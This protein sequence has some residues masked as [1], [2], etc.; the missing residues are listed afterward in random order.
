MNRGTGWFA[1]AFGLLVGCASP[2]QV[3]EF[4]A[5]EGNLAARAAYYLRAGEIGSPST[6]EPGDRERLDAG[7]QAAIRAELTKKGYVETTDASRAQFVVSYQVAGTRRIVMA[8]DRRFG[9]PSPNSVL[10]PSA[11]PPPPLSEAPREQVVRSG[12]VMVLAEEPASGAV[13]WRGMISA[14]TRVGSSEQGI[15][16]AEDMARHITQRFPAR[17]GQ[18]PK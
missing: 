2:W 9:A 7:L 13:L 12:S 4:A 8:D 3:D 16:V 5:P 10:S 14:D 11:T 17:P 18:A 15:R 6:V 1:V